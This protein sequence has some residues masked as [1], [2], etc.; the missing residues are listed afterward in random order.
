MVSKLA[1]KRLA[2]IFE[3]ALP[4]CLDTT[5]YHTDKDKDTFVITGDITAMWLRDSTNQLL[6]Y[7]PLAPTDPALKAM[8]CGAIRRQASQ[9]RLNR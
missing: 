3:N 5:I 6:P 1:D 7:V 9:V 2:R 8:L 4:N